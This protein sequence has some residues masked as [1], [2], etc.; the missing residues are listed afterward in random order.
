MTV[1]KIKEGDLAFTPNI[2]TPFRKYLTPIFREF[3][4]S[5]K[6]SVRDSDRLRWKTE[7]YNL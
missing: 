1:A 3:S 4:F 7:K 2:K 6:F 5:Q